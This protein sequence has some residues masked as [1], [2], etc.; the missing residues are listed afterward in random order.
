MLEYPIAISPQF[1]SFE[2]NVLCQ[3]LRNVM[4][5]LSIDSLTQWNAQFVQF[6]KHF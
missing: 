3:M 2:L 6:L 1:K 4:V 5:E